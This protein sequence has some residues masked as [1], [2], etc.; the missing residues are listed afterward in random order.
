MVLKT[1]M[2]WKQIF[3]IVLRYLT[4]ILS[5]ILMCIVISGCTNTSNKWYF[6]RLDV[7]H[8][9]IANGIFTTLKN[10][11]NNVKSNTNNGGIGLTT[12][13]IL[14]LTSYADSQ[15]KE[16]PQFIVSGMWS[17]CSGEYKLSNSTATSTSSLNSTLSSSPK[18]ESSSDVSVH[19]EKRY[20]DYCSDPELHYSFNYKT[21]LAS[22]GLSI[23]L[24]YAYSGNIE[25]IETPS[26]TTVYWTYASNWGLLTGGLIF[27]ILTL[28]T[29]IGS[30]YSK[31]SKWINTIMSLFFFTSLLFGCIAATVLNA[32]LR[33]NIIDELGAFNIKVYL[34]KRVF[35]T[36][37]VC[38]GLSFVS[39]LAWAGPVWCVMTE[40]DQP[41]GKTLLGDTTNT[42]NNS[43]SSKKDTH[44]EVVEVED[45]IDNGET[46]PLSYSDQQ[47]ESSTSRFKDI[48][49][50]DNIF[51]ELRFDDDNDS[52]KPP[53][54]YRNTLRSS[55]TAESLR[56]FNTLDSFGG[57]ERRS[58][59]LERADE[60]PKSKRF[61]YNSGNIL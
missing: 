44:N 55:D 26:E 43:S 46:T 49:K 19:E 53:S 16:S 54:P 37:W 40:D 9:D 45:D 10:E 23:I 6:L 17:W 36:I 30:Y 38:C 60:L 18:V 20:F 51:N 61:T 35:T 13:E 39:F 15:V 24:P 29:G 41:E 48:N 28:L 11:V 57:D 50:D 34:G 59:I 7:L 52:L 27:P 14:A 47:P 42:S 12:S 5:I 31:W 2:T 58:R 56:S 21:T 3:Q 8:T 22:S 1:S 33:Q 32:D 4:I 25:N